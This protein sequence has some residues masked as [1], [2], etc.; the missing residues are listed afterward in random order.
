MVQ[1]QRLLPVIQLD[2]L[3]GLLVSLFSLHF[4]HLRIQGEHKVKLLRCA[5][6]E[7]R[8]GVFDGGHLGLPLRDVC[9]IHTNV[10]NTDTPIFPVHNSPHTLLDDTTKPEA[11]NKFH[12]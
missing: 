7:E 3:L 6:C 4:E 9:G 11:A 8:S 5:V 1:L 12:T 10:G 2:Q